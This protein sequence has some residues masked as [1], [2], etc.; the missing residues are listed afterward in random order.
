MEKYI[1]SIKNDIRI[2]QIMYDICMEKIKEF[3]IKSQTYEI[4]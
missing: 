1:N 2:Y 4:Y 3:I